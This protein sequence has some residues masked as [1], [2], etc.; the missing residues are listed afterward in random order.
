MN[1]AAAGT[2]RAVVAGRTLSALAI[3]FLGFSAIIKFVAPGPV[4]ESMTQLGFPPQLST[5]I[6]GL[7][8]ACTLLYAVPRT[9]RI[10]AILLTGHLGGACA[11]HLR[12]LDPWLT[13]TLF[14]IW[15][16]A[17]LWAGLLLRD[18]AFRDLLVSAGRRQRAA[19]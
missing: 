6:G 18:A 3:A 2:P 12:L 14:P 4:R 11:A 8:L 19:A 7:E 16:G 5:W 1:A 10:G 9:A 17:L 13:H 15:L